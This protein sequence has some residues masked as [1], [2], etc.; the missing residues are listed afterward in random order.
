L[1]DSAAPDDARTLARDE[2]RQL[3]A[4]AWLTAGSSGPFALAKRLLLAGGN[5]RDICR[6]EPAPLS[7]AVALAQLSVFAA[8]VLLR[9]VPAAARDRVAL[10]GTWFSRAASTVGD[11]RAGPLAES[12]PAASSREVWPQAA[13]SPTT[14]QRAKRRKTLRIFPSLRGRAVR[15]DCWQGANRWVRPRRQAEYT[16]SLA[17]SA[18]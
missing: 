10:A 16:L 15:Q 6:F 14:I 11:I 12:G 13:T 18:S 2:R 1:P 4:T 8:A 7:L 3:L 17:S 5:G 9:F